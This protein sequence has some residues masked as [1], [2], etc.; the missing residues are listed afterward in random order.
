MLEHLPYVLVSDMLFQIVF[1]LLD[2]S[3]Y[4]MKLK[5]S[6]L[7]GF[8]WKTKFDFQVWNRFLISNLKIK[9]CIGI[10]VG[11]R[12]FPIRSGKCFKF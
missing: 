2:I 9:F 3:S 12:M 11:R 7:M 5:Y 10:N 1:Y 6:K 8:Y 4:D